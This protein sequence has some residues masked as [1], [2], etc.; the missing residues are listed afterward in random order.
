MEK[1]NRHTGSSL[2]HL[3][4]ILIHTTFYE[5]NHVIQYTFNSKIY[6][7]QKHISKSLLIFL[8]SSLFTMWINWE[9]NELFIYN[10]QLFEEM[11]FCLFWKCLKIGSKQSVS[12][13]SNILSDLIKQPSGQR[14]FTIFAPNSTIPLY[15]FLQHTLTAWCGWD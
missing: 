7:Y 14:M 9:M 13:L 1:P 12:K 4:T 8:T 3:D 11:N 5:V 15:H 6:I 10:L 2:R